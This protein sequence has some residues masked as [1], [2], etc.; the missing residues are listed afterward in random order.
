MDTRFGDALRALAE[1]IGPNAAG[2]REG[3]ESGT[4]K[5]VI[6]RLRSGV[7]L[8]EHECIEL[9]HLLSGEMATPSRGIGRNSLKP[10]QWREVEEELAKHKAANKAR[11]KTSGEEHRG[12]RSMESIREEVAEWWNEKYPQAPCLTAEKINEYTRRSKKRK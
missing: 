11:R 7:P 5:A 9:A 2:L 10:H 3:L 1:L 6:N 12:R 8:E 4:T